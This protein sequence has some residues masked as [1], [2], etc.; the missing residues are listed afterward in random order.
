MLQRYILRSPSLLHQPKLLFLD[1]PTI[2]LD[3]V[4]KERIRQFIRHANR[5]HGTTIILT[6]HDL[7]DV[8]RLCERVLMIDQ[9]KL[10]Y[11]GQLST[12]IERFETSRLLVLTFDRE[13]EPVILPGIPAP[14][15]QGRQLQ[16]TFD[17]T[18]SS[19]T[20]L[21][22]QIQTSASI[23]DL[24][25]RRPDLESTVRRIYEQGLLSRWNGGVSQPEYPP[26]E[27]SPEL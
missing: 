5:A 6:T 27:T 4:A 14:I 9:G 25:I 21:L 24:E 22:N 19:A 2:G 11:D 1:E 7:T 8:E 18:R 12:L 3:V 10:L 26:E 15:Q 17:S 16:Y 23:V 20:D 13:V